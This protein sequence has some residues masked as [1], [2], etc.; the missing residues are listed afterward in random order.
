[1]LFSDTYI[2]VGVYFYACQSRISK[3]QLQVFYLNFCFYY[4]V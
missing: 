2:Q 3:Q 1:M 4:Y